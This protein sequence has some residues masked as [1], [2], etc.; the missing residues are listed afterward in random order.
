MIEFF[1]AIFLGVVQGLTEFLPVSSSGHLILAKELFGI[2]AE[3]FG[4]AF[5]V[6][7]HF[8]TF[9][10]VLIFFWRDILRL[11]SAFFKNIKKPFSNQDS[12]LASL[13]LI[14]T[15]PAG[16]IGLLLESRMEELF[17]SAYVVVFM[18]VFGGVAFLLVEKFVKH[19]KELTDIGIKEA[20]LIGLGQALALIPGTSRSGA[21]ITVGLILGLKREAATRFSFLLSSPIILV[22]GLKEVPKIIKEGNGTVGLEVYFAGFLT[23][24]VA[25]YLAIKFLISYLSK[26]PL[27]VFAYYRFLLAFAVLAYLILK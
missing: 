5:D 7:L 8:G 15:I 11:F 3:T 26:H 27:N 14:G 4:L 24:F 13:F 6:S 16:L 25:G 19:T 21:T 23:A 10:A 22:A 18:L 9:F 2:N 1:Q 12:K 17:R 20:L